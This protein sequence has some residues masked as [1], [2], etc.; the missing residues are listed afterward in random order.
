MMSSQPMNCSPNREKCDIHYATH[1]MQIFS[2]KLAKT[3]TNVG[4]VQLYGYI[5]VRDDHDSLLNYVV[6]RSRDDPI[7]VDQEL[8]NNNGFAGFFYW[9]D[10]P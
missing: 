8:L 6:D 2:L 7:I 9:D 5:A 10:W 4:L 3:S 1:M